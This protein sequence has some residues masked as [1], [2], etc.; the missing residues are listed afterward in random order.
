MHKFQLVRK[1]KI[2]HK[3]GCSQPLGLFSGRDQWPINDCIHGYDF[4]VVSF[5]DK[6]FEVVSFAS[7]L[8]ST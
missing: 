8:S 6:N 2:N 7:K 1:F 3:E 5:L 4:E